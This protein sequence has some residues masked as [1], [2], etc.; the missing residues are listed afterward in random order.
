M[1]SKNKQK[2]LYELELKLR[3]LLEEL[4]INEEFLSFI[5]VDMTD[6]T[7]RFLELKFDKII[8]ESMNNNEDQNST[9]ADVNIRQIKALE[10]LNDFDAISRREYAITFGVSFMT[11]FRDLVQLEKKGLVS[12]IGRARGTK[13]ILKNK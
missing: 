8:Q 9:L 11:A 7:I 4:K 5:K 6:K 3:S 2:I 10:Y 12:I 13:Y 1:I